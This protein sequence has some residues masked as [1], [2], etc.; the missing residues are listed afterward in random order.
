MIGSGADMLALS[1]SERSAPNG[2]EFTISV[3]G[4][5]I[6]GVQSTNANVLA[7]QAQTFDVE[8]TFAPGNHTVAINYLNASNSLLFVNSTT[9]DGAAVANG[10]LTLSNNG[11]QTIS[12]IEQAAAT[13]STAGATVLGNGPDTLALTLSERSSPDAQFTISVNG[14]QVGGVQTVTANSLA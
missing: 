14:Q 9:I 1:M 8:G 13:A 2:A 12:F 5:Q 11:S 6:G 4:T 7:N 10:S 3:D